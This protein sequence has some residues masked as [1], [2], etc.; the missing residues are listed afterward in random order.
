MIIICIVVVSRS[1]TPKHIS[2]LN[3]VQTY[4]KKQ[5]LSQNSFHARMA[6]FAA[7]R[8]QQLKSKRLHPG[9]LQDDLKSIYFLGFSY[10]QAY[11]VAKDFRS[12]GAS[13]HMVIPY[14]IFPLCSQQIC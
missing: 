11:V 13:K 8:A 7:K 3:S 14:V 9:N 12:L 4:H 10:P 6:T 1:L 5:S 2:P